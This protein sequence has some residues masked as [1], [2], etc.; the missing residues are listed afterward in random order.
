MGDYSACQLTTE[1]LICIRRRAILIV[2]YT[3][4]VEFP[5]RELHLYLRLF[6]LASAV[7]SPHAIV[8]IILLL[9]L[10][11]NTYAL[12]PGFG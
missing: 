4:K 10:G 7:I 12:Q 8:P 1:L 3:R 5:R 2:Y 11:C 6:L 9:G